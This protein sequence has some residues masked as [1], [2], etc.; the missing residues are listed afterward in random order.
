MKVK[1]RPRV[2]TSIIIA[3]SNGKKVGRRHSL[4]QPTITPIFRHTIH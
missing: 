1:Q 2:K 3:S 4:V